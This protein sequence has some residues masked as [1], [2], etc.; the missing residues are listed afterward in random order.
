V[1]GPTARIVAQANAAIQVSDRD[2]RLLTLRR[3][4][5]LDRLRL[6]KAIGPVLAQNPPYLG[7]AMLASS[8]T[9]IDDVPVPAPATEAQVEALIS[10]LGDSGI[11]A[12]ADGLRPDVEQ[13]RDG[14]DL[15]GN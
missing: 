14:G 8:V 15:P 9:A 11:A 12:A 10:R 1:D 5:A 7:M 6:F 13:D 2:G 3:M 4:G